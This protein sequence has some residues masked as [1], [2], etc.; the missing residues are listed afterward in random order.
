LNGT[1]HREERRE[2]SIRRTLHQRLVARHA[3]DPETAILHELDIP[4]PSARV[5]LA[6]I[7]GRI[8]GYEIKS[9]RDN[10]VRLRDQEV[11][12][13][14]VFETMSLVVATRHLDKAMQAV[15]DWWEILEVIGD[16]MCIRQRGR[17]NPHLNLENL[18]HLLTAKEL[19]WA[20]K[21]LGR[22]QP[23]SGRQ[24]GDTICDILTQHRPNEV[25]SC[26]REVLKLRSAM[27]P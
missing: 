3:H 10:L 23:P 18:L 27:L 25:K 17:L 22:K 4:R 13:S 14:S 9:A 21:I 26:V 16:R 8:A 2:A 11:S 5:D 19:I 6:V 12:F 7:N 24:K 15:P 1:D 20:S